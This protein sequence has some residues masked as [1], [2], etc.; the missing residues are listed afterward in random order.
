MNMAE[1]ALLATVLV[2]PPALGA[3]AAFR[4][5]PWWWAAM[6]AVLMAMVAAIAPAPEAG[7]PRVAAGDLGFLLVVA[8]WVTGLAWAGFAL[9]RRFGV[10]RGSPASPSS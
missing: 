3:V 6:A 1:L 10:S 4:R 8:A 5:R 9:T 2:L 7:E